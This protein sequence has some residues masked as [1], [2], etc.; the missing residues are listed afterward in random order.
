MPRSSKTRS[1][2]EAPKPPR[3]AASEPRL[4]RSR[5]PDELPVEAWQVG[6]RRQFGRD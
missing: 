4:S 1:S 2:R 5:K 3:R 6:L